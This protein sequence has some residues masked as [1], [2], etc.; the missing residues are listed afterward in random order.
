MYVFINRIKFRANIISANLI[1][2]FKIQ[3]QVSLKFK[4]ILISI[5]Y[6]PKSTTSAGTYP[7]RKHDPLGLHNHKLIQKINHPKS[8]VDGNRIHLP[9]IIQTPPAIQPAHHIGS[10]VSQRRQR[11]LTCHP[12]CPSPFPTVIRT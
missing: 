4:K 10:E 11:L 7:N 9:P 12:T 2:F 6:P 3:I 5:N 8:D 1:I